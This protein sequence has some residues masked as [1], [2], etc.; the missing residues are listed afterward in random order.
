MAHVIDIADA[1]ATELLTGTFSMEFTPVRR[2]L[3]KF[4]L[5]DLDNLLVTVVPAA[6]DIL[7][8]SRIASQYDVSVDIGIQKRISRA[9]MDADVL[10]L[11]DLVDE[12]G[13]FLKMRALA[14]APTAHWRNMK[15]E[16]IY[17]V[18]H[19]LENRTFTSVLSLTYV[20]TE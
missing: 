15:N 12:I 9:S 13:D 2:V 5:K 16:P 10:A 1:I 14:D 4:D 17:S 6:V 18:E 8:A 20:V 7:A 3:P 11:C 19:L